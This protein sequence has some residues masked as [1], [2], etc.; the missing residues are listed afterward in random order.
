MNIPFFDVKPKKDFKLDKGGTVI[1][2]YRHKN[3]EDILYVG[4]DMHTLCIGATRSGKSRTVVLESIALQALAGEN[5]A[6][7]D[8]KG[9][10]TRS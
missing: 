7:S 3:R 5:I 4:G 8:P 1:G 6:C 9:G 2:M 10:A